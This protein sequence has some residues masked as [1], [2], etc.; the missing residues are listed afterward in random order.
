VNPPPMADAEKEV[1]TERRM[2]SLPRCDCGDRAVI[3]EDTA[4]HFV[5][6]NFDYVS[7]SMH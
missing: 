4:K 7:P 2:D 3:D 5:C 1:A 6:L